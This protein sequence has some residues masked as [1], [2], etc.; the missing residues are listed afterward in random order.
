MTKR[1]MILLYILVVLAISG[2]SKA[3]SVN[4]DSINEAYIK[5]ISVIPQTGMVSIIGQGSNACQRHPRIVLE[6]MDEAQRIIV[7]GIMTS[8]PSVICNLS[9]PQ[10]FV[11]NYD[12]NNLP[13]IPGI[14]YT[15]RFNKSQDE[16]L[17]T[18]EY[19]AQPRQDLP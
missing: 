11:L 8:S 17:T 5:Q 18:A 15:I 3:D 12:L 4:A 7:F 19:I 13:L 2:F 9:F 14:S 6:S 10:N 1:I 16:K